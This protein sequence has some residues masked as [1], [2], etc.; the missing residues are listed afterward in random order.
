MGLQAR[1]FA[2]QASVWAVWF[3]TFSKALLQG[4]LMETHWRPLAP[5]SFLCG[6]AGDFKI[7]QVEVSGCR[8]F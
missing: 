2:N 5:G 3:K 7:E 1:N 4:V 8:L 6:T